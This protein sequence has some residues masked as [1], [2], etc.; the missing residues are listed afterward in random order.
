MVKLKREK[1]MKNL[2]R[3]T[4]RIPMELQEKIKYTA[5]FN[6]RSRNKEFEVAIK[7][8]IND[9]ERLYGTISTTCEKD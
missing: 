9:F 6:C 8:Y 5:K 1:Q 4:L 2:T 7:R 3:Y